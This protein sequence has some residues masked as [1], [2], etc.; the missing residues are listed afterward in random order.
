MPLGIGVSRTT[1][2]NRRPMTIGAQSYYNVVRPDGSA[3]QLLRPAVTLLYPTPP[4]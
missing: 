2:F 3:G 4:H 1:V